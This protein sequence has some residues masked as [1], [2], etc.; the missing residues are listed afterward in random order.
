MKPR[1][2]GKKKEKEK[3]HNTV[4]KLY[5]KRF[6]NYYDQY[7]ELSHAE[8]DK[9]NQKFKPINLKLKDYDYDGWFTEEELDNKR[10]EGD[11]KELS[12]TTRR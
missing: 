2:L 8:I 6:K 4:S 12:T 5:N 9:L 11:E 10:P 7:D 3:V 1:S